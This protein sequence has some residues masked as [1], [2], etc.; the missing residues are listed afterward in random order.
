MS[1]ELC[2]PLESVPNESDLQLIKEALSSVKNLQFNLPS[3]EHVRVTEAGQ[4]L[5]EAGQ[6]H[7]DAKLRT[8]LVLRSPN[9]PD[10]ELNRQFN[11][12]KGTSK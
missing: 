9:A 3:V 12:I 11:W 10:A 2:I 8:E 1:F 6:A 5:R 4:R 7:E